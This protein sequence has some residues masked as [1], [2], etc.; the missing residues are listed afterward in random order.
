MGWRAGSTR[1]TNHFCALGC[2]NISWYSGKYC[3]EREYRR[4][5]RYRLSKIFI[6]FEF[7]SYFI[8]LIVLSSRFWWKYTIRILKKIHELSFIFH[9]IR[10]ECIRVT[11]EGQFFSHR[12]RSYLFIWA[13]FLGVDASIRFSCYALGQIGAVA[14]KKRC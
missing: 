10:E 6:L 9:I 13:N 4:S 1:G 14:W 8:V 2:Q 3:R 12:A 7:C 5:L 11:P